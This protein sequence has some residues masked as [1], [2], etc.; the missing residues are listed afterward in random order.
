[1]EGG[2]RGDWP[3]WWTG[4][5]GAGGQG[6][7]PVAGGEVGVMVRLVVDGGDKRRRSWYG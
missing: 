7:R 4:R 5:G 2:E 1:M 3:G 6:A